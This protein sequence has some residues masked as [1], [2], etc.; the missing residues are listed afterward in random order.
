MLF[1]YKRQYKRHIGVFFK[2]LKY[3][4]KSSHVE[5]AHALHTHTHTYNDSRKI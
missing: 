1:A 3:L 4:F 5:L 2:R